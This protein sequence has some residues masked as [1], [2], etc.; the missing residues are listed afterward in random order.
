M[1][2]AL[3]IVDLTAMLEGDDGALSEL[4]LAI[5]EA[6]RDVGFFYLA[7]HGIAPAL[8]AKIFE[9]SKFFFA[10]PLDQKDTLS[11]NRS[12]H[13]RAMPRSKAKA[14]TRPNRPI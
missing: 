6:A 8:L 4:S 13:N 12:P 5:G 7:G 3:P 2:D 9:L 14:S 1:S 10:Q 11:I